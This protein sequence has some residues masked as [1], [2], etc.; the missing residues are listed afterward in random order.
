[1]KFGETEI[2]ATAVDLTTGQVLLYFFFP[3]ISQYSQH[4][5]G[6]FYDLFFLSSISQYFHNRLFQYNIFTTGQVILCFFVVGNISMF[7][8]D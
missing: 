5:T 7:H 4:R 8:Q 2:K 1:M 3:S 6:S